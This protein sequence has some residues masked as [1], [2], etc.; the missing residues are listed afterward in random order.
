MG[1]YSTIFTNAKTALQGLVT[2]GNLAYVGELTDDKQALF[3]KQSPCCGIFSV[4]NNFSGA[5]GS[6]IDGLYTL[7]IM[8][9]VFGVYDR[10]KNIDDLIDLI[11]S[12][13]QNAACTVPSIL[14]I[15]TVSV[16]YGEPTT[17]NNEITAVPGYYGEKS[18]V[19]IEVT[20][21]YR[22]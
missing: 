20:Y 14:T 7:G 16:I 21:T 5:I 15:P 11:T 4:N 12:T 18:I 22:Q 17:D 2:A 13:L 6:R 9:V 3:G 19:R 8:L 10:E 1:T